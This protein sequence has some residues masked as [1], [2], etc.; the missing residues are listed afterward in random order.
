MGVGALS[1]SS[2]FCDGRNLNSLKCQANFVFWFN[3]L[4]EPIV[5]II[6]IYM[7]HSVVRSSANGVFLSYWW[8]RI[9]GYIFIAVYLV[10]IFSADLIFKIIDIDVGRNEVSKPV[11]GEFLRYWWSR[12]S[13]FCAV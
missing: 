3:F 10:L 2:S 13:R 12:G 5:K 6:D 11:I 4:T 1:A 9:P 8:S 7:G